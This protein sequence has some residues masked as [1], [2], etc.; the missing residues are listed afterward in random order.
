M[1]GKHSK[2]VWLE[3]IK[4][5]FNV[6]SLAVFLLPRN[7]FLQ[8]HSDTDQKPHSSNHIRKTLPASS[9]M[10]SGLSLYL[11]KDEISVHI[12]MDSSSMPHVIKK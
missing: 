12:L 3:R 8:K 11:S 9:F 4:L 2:I 7:P 1:L 10:C 6:C 5:V